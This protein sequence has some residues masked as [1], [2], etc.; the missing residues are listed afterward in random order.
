MPPEQYEELTEGLKVKVDQ[1]AE[2]E[3]TLVA[4]EKE[5]KELKDLCDMNI[6][7]LEET[8]KKKAEVEMKL[9]V[10]KDTLVDTKLQLISSQKDLDVTQFIVKQQARAE[11]AL[12]GSH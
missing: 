8:R 12:S 9:E 1:V 4:K 10:T 7:Q 5:L 3:C 2:L 6:S 11:S